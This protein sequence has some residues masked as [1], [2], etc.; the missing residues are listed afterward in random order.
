[1]K[2]QWLLLAIFT[3][4]PYVVLGAAGAWWLYE[5]GWALWWVAWAALVSLAGWPL[6]AWLKKRSATL[7]PTPAGPAGDWSPVGTA[8]WADVEAIARRLH[9]E[10]IAIDRPEPLLQLAREVVE[11]VARRF[12]PRAKNPAFE[13]PVPHL[14]QIAELVAHDLRE[15]V[16]ENIPGSHILTINDLVR[17]KRMAV[18]V[19]NLYRLYRVVML[20]VNPASAIARE[21]S[22]MGQEKML[23]AS[24]HETKRWAL[25]FAVRRAGFYAIELYSGH[26]VL[27]G[28]EFAPYVTGRS[29]RAIDR[30]KERT[31][32]LDE[33]PL[34]V[35]ILGQV[36]AGKSSLVNALFGETRAAVDVVPLTKGIEPYLLERDGFRRAIILDTAGY[37]EAA[38]TADALEQARDEVLQCDLVILASSAQTAAREADRRLL[39]EVRRL[40][41]QQP[42]REFPPLVVALTH[43]D[44]LR[45][46]REWNPPYNL[47]DPRDT[48]SANIR[49]ALEATAGD[50]AVDIERV[51][52]VCLLEGKLYNVDEALISAILD[53]LDSARRLKYLRCLREYKDEEYWRRL[54]QQAA[55]AGRILLSAGLEVLRSSVRK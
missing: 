36:K 37:A 50:L 45:P 5:S 10:E 19:P 40:F 14:L 9:T 28:I 15:A 29:R 35:L 34:R 26:L 20:I 16:S 7:V 38:R 48:K 52:P 31:T 32:A 18:L 44:Q 6:A 41:Q 49:E 47:A 8:A 53:Q 21:I 11:A 1:L 51:V 43:I 2:A 23:N 13:I 4:L 33:E 24:A 42:D 54:R 17:L 27:R 46:F 30:D 55:N 25:Q 3:T 22:L 39:D 12:Y